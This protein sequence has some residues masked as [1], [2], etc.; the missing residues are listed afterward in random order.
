[1]VVTIAGLANRRSWSMLRAR[2]GSSRTVPS[3]R[4]SGGQPVRPESGS[5][6]VRDDHQEPVVG[7]SVEVAGHDSFGSTNGSG[8][9]PRCGSGMHRDVREDRSIAA[10]A[11]LY[12]VLAEQPSRADAETQCREKGTVVLSLVRGP[13]VQGAKGQEDGGSEAGGS[14][15]GI[16]QV[17]LL[18]SGPR[19]RDRPAQGYGLPSRSTC[20]LVDPEPLIPSLTWCF[21]GRCTLTCSRRRFQ[22]LWALSRLPW[23]NARLRDCDRLPPHLS[24]REQESAPSSLSHWRQCRPRPACHQLAAAHLLNPASQFDHF[25]AVLTPGHAA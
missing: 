10:V 6:A 13:R 1:M 9:V 22:S 3:A 17:G 24:G 23:A 5:R 20:L 15:G 12:Q 16:R 4:S 25:R 14:E 18:G 11:A 19:G 21:P 2:T 8:N 7:E